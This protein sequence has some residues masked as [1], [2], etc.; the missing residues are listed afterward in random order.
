MADEEELGPED[1]AGKSARRQ[2]LAR[3]DRTEDLER[4][5][6]E[7]AGIDQGEFD[8]LHAFVAPRLDVPASLA[9]LRKILGNLA[10][11]TPTIEQLD[12]ELAETIAQIERWRARLLSIP[13]DS[14]FWRLSPVAE[15]APKR[16]AAGELVVRPGFKGIIDEHPLWVS[17][18]YRSGTEMEQSA[19]AD[20]DET[21]RLL[22]A[23]LVACHLRL[24][25][26]ERLDEDAHIRLAE[27][28]RLL[29]SLH[30]PDLGP[31]LDAWPE[32]ATT[33]GAIYDE[34]AKRHA[35]RGERYRQG[36]GALAELIHLAFGL[37]GSIF[38]DR[39]VL[40]LGPRSGGK[41]R[42]FQ[43]DRLL[44]DHRD[45]WYRLEMP[46]PGIDQGEVAVERRPGN[47]EEDRELASTGLDPEEFGGDLGYI[48]GFDELLE[49]RAREVEGDTE[50]LGDLPPL[51]SLYAAA[52]AR[53]RAQIMR[54]QH[55]T[56]RSARVRDITLG[57]IVGV[58]NTLYRAPATEDAKPTKDEIERA[59]R[60]RETLRFCAA[61]MVTGSSP[62]ALRTLVR[63]TRREEL[64]GGWSISYAPEHRVWL[65][66][67]V[68]P[69]R[70][71]LAHAYKNQ[72]V[73]TWPQVA[74]SDVWSVGTHL[75]PEGRYFASQERTFRK[76][77]NEIVAPRLAS[78]GVEA[79]WRKFNA[80]PGLI[81]DWFLG[82]E[83]GE[84]L[85]IGMLFGLPDPGSESP[86]F[87]TALDRQ[88]LDRFYVDTMSSLWRAMQ[89]SAEPGDLLFPRESATVPKSLCGDDRVPRVETVR[90]LVS[91]MRDR[92]ERMRSEAGWVELH[93]ELVA[94][95]GV[96]L[97]IVT[98]FRSV[99]TPIPD[100][101]LVDR[102]TG[103]MAMQEK[104]REDGSHARL[105]WVPERVR[106][107]IQ[108][109]LEQV[110][111][112]L[113]RHGDELG[114]M[115]RV[116]ATKHRDR[117]RVAGSSFR[118]PLA[119]TLFFLV[120]EPERRIRAEEFT[121]DR[122][123][124]HL[125]AVLPGYWPAENAGR[126]FLR[127]YLANSGC[128]ETFVHTVMGHWGAGEASW[129]PHS[130]L[131]PMRF[132]EGVAPLLERLLG[133]IDFRAVEA[134]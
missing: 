122:L 84:R 24:V 105:V 133:H 27:A 68:P 41:R 18:W 91:A 39:M 103:F 97:A 90:A 19:G 99:R 121:G 30:Q 17:L 10:A 92:I 59:E 37:G 93:N 45:F 111:R 43:F 101:T 57:R 129:G 128:P 110:H 94:Y 52:R 98:G 115:L 44:R 83:E 81:P 72:R 51:G 82:R 130:A 22:Q 4:A 85:R 126:H 78:A 50:R 119:S 53:Y 63:Y 86:R 75:P 49:E 65:R 62:D 108:F 80:L 102:H 55:F 25:E 112:V 15:P 114:V 64:P 46:M 6:G 54:A 38:Q 88:A 107:Q 96:A 66:P 100:L 61:M 1:A 123:K 132:R 32:R 125:D 12:P 23:S 76:I 109:Y 16:N 36:Y 106:R 2:F 120:T 11:L 47:D 95:L 5:L 127:T 58:F 71:S 42:A 77:F 9:G 131:D 87:Y 73:S 56:T 118:L 28:S 70:N 21:Y 33:L 60:L 79:R 113:A 124:A 14:T 26:W 48:V 104:D 8:E 89:V 134:V 67:Y 40:R 29:R 74:L 34:L 20:R 116:A 7:C 35:S 3:K 117:S 31:A 69:E 13:A